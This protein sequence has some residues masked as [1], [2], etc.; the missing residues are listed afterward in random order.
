MNQFVTDTVL[1]SAMK[2]LSFEFKILNLPCVIW[3]RGEPKG[4]GLDIYAIAA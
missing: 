2:I 4:I 3:R 1:L